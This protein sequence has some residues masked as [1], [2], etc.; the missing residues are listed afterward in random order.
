MQ[1]PATRQSLTMFQMHGAM[2]S[3]G[4][5]PSAAA[6]PDT[7]LEESAPSPVQA[8]GRA[9]PST[10]LVVLSP[11]RRES[12]GGFPASSNGPLSARG[13]LASPAP[14]SDAPTERGT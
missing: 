3:S 12:A 5:G 8:W 9:A 6:V 14:P 13:R 11:L 10:E 2:Q 1:S 4:G 7:V